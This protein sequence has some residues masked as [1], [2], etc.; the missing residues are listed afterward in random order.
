M[1]IF[2]V[3]V[4]VD[5]GQDVSM[6]HIVDLLPELRVFVRLEHL[7]GRCVCEN[8]IEDCSQIDGK[9]DGDAENDPEIDGKQEG[10]DGKCY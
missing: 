10:I 3:L 8:S 1:V 4:L 9:D 5:P 7:I 6:D 2:G